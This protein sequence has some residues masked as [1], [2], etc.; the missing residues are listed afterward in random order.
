MRISP[1]LL[2]CAIVLL[3]LRGEPAVAQNTKENADFKLAINLY[4]D[5]L[6][7]LAA[8]QLKQFIA[9]FPNTGQGV[10]A[11]FYLGLTQLKLKQYDEARLT[12]QTFALTYQDNPKAPEAWWKVGESYAA[13]NNY[14]EAALAFE[15][16]K[17]FHPRS[18]TAGAA[19]VEAGKYFGLAGQPDDARRVLRI[20]MQE[21]ASSTAVLAARTQLG[22][23]YFEEGNLEQAQNEL[24]R[25][26]EGDPSPDAKAQALLILGNI[27]GAMGKH[28]EALKNYQEVITKH[29]KTSA[30]QGAYVNLAKLQS[31]R[32]KYMEAVDNF[33]KALAE[34]G[35][36]DSALVREAMVGTG[37]A[38]A[39]LR[40]YSNAVKYYNNFTA[41]FPADTLVAYVWWKSALVNVNARNYKRSNELC[42]QIIKSGASEMLKRRAQIRL[43]L[44]AEEQK[45]AAQAV[46]AYEQ[47]IDQ[48]PDDRATPGILM[49]I[50]ALA[51]NELRDFRKAAASYELIMARY[52][53]SPFVDDAYA[54]AARCY[55]Q[56]KDFDR[57]MQVQRQLLENF[58]SSDLREKTV[59]RISV[60]ETFEA[61]DKDKGL[62]RLA[63]LLGDVVA[64]RDKMGLAYRLGEVYF[65]DLKNYEAAAQQFTNAINSGMTD[66]RFVTALYLRARSYEYLSWKED[67]Y[68][69]QAIES[70]TTFL[71]SYPTDTRA[72][73]AALALFR[74]RATTLPASREAYISVL[75]KFPALRGRQELLLHI[76]RKLMEADSIPGALAT[77]STIVRE[78][79]TSPAAE[80]AGFSRMQLL[81]QTGLADS[82]FS[83]GA[84]YIRTFPNG[85]HTA[86]V[87]A[88]L[89]DA[90]F[91][92]NVHASAIE[93]YRRLSSDFSYTIQGNAA[94]RRLADAYAGAGNF[95][96]AIDLYTEL[97][98]ESA[99]DPFEYDGGDGSLYLALGTALQASGNTAAAKAYLF[100]FLAQQPS[101][102]TAGNA[103]SLLGAIYRKEG[104]LDL[105]T[106]YFRQAGAVAPNAPPSRDI[107]GLLYESGN[108]A[109][110]LKQYMQLSQSA[111]AESDKQFFDARVILCRLKLD[112]LANAEKDITAFTAK[113]RKADED[114]ASFE[115]E[116][117]NHFYRKRDLASANRSFE[118][119]AS[120]YSN[121]PS[122]P[123]AMYWSGKILE[124]GNKL[125]DAIKQYERIQKQ[126]PKSPILQRVYLAL[127]NIYYNAEKWDESVQN[128]RRIVDDSNADPELLP[129]A[130]SNLIETYETAGVFDAAL[131]LTRKYLE[132]YPNNEDSFDKKIKI[133][134]LYQ[135]LGY[136][137][138][139]V[140]HLTTL[141]D[142]AGSDLEGEIRYY[143]AEANYNKGDYQQAILD[144]LKVPYLVTKKGKIDWTANSLYMSGQSYERMGRHD[145]ALTMYQQI[146][147]RP[148]IDEMFKAAARKEIARVRSVLG[149]SN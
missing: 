52:S 68:R 147:D 40:D 129:L 63:L 29:P 142:E 92:S 72:N 114:L 33:Q 23:I 32:G 101:G 36:V 56:L 57:A 140:L 84:A 53:R 16:V 119:V 74:L 4:N 46:Q 55:E 96:E 110:A 35:V 71:D 62:E 108:H 67:R 42:T 49:R 3:V 139:S 54:G 8:E 135:R 138:Q 124:A 64:D 19:L 83:A 25:V 20:V 89:G 22:R 66:D 85:S 80:E 48:R 7:E 21:Y 37:D 132:A 14:R 44:N 130:M 95:E 12:F 137:D 65:H 6:Y 134:I 9:S 94:R 111:T 86:E 58:P 107:A 41:S 109:D 117:G 102:E 87:L 28:D 116:K 27:A 90:A 91:N 47:F 26:V 31:L 50:G 18:T 24:R 131:T 145:Q 34:K 122:A 59:E 43:A 136:N 61:K 45:S 13:V 82:A 75:R 98:E 76:G 38:Y 146:L 123:I 141:L 104:S 125:P 149:K 15:R 144:F 121:S 77:F 81:A 17:V 127:G 97:V 99:S 148:G 1:F 128:Y 11:R 69:Q 100:R 73:D 120:K 78:F 30:M 10:E 51:E 133:G 5:A 60:I 88:L 2:A 126:Y 103:Y 113:Y 39:S 115:L 105:A 70:Y 79:P 106:S 93:Y 112:D 118:R 143:I